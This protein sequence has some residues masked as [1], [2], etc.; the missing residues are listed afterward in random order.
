MLMECNLCS[1]AFI[2]HHFVI[3]CVWVGGWVVVLFHISFI[4][5]FLCS[6]RRSFR[7]SGGLLALQSNHVGF[8]TAAQ[9]QP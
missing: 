6:E 1:S 8:G 2:C 5:P 4:W 3:E 9:N 7:V